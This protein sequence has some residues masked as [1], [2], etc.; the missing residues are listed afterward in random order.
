MELN[1]MNEKEL[2]TIVGRMRDAGNKKIKRLQKTGLNTPALQQVERSGGLFS[3][4]GKTL[5]ELRGEFS[6]IRSFMESRTSTKTGFEKVRQETAEKLQEKGVDITPDQMDKMFNIY[7][8]LKERDPSITTQKMKYAVMTEISKMSDD[9]DPEAAI[10]AM[11]ERLDDLYEEQAG[12]NGDFD[13]V[14]EFFEI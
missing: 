5:N 4:K 14:S 9:I 1:T 11:Q 8:K 13:S 6:R 10:L 7:E 3:T 12:I 2:R